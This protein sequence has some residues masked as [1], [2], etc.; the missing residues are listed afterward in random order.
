M[1]IVICL[2]FGFEEDRE[3]EFA[4]IICCKRGSFPIKYLG[5]PLHFSKLKREDLQPVIDKVIRIIAGWRIGYC[6]MQA[7]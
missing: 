3:N 2:L 5:V 6:L 7:G 1:K 4:K